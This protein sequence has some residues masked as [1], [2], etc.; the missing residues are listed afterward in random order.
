M[1][2]TYNSYI[3]EVYINEIFMAGVAGLEPA[4]IG[5]EDRS[6]TIELHPLEL[7]IIYF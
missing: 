2:Y 5:F 3:S 1:Y 7:K 6:S 4:T